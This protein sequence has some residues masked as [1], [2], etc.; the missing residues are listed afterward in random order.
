ML[1]GEGGGMGGVLKSRWPLVGPGQPW[2]IL[3]RKES[4]NS[5]QDY[6]APGKL[7]WEKGRGGNW[8]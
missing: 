7:A 1:W 6:L 8:K 2:M 3:Y 5:S 4:Q